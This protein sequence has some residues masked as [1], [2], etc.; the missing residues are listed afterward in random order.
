MFAP[1]TTCRIAS[2][3]SRVQSYCSRVQSYCSRAVL[4]RVVRAHVMQIFA[5][6]TTCRIVVVRV[7]CN[8]IAGV[9]VASRVQS[10]CSRGSRVQ[11]CAVES[12]AVSMM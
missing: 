10:Y 3:A 8:R 11:S 1:N 6:N 9:R 4:T 7:V 5:P 12:R 2:S